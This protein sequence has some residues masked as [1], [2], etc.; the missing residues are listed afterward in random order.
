MMA[1]TMT[2]SNNVKP[3]CRRGVLSHPENDSIMRM[4]PSLRYDHLCDLESHG[5]RPAIQTAQRA[6]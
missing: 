6:R 4:L 2:S 5:H 3:A 1:T